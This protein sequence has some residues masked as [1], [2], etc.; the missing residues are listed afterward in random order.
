MLHVVCMLSLVPINLSVYMSFD[1][2][3]VGMQSIQH[4]HVAVYSEFTPSFPTNSAGEGQARW[5]GKAHQ[6]CSS[7]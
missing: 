7:R 6:C 5:Q 3:T 2:L 1:L 4:M